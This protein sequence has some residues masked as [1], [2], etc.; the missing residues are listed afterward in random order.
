MARDTD[1]LVRAAQRFGVKDERVLEAVAAVP[2]EHFVPDH[3]RRSAYRDRPIP[4]G[5]GQT[6][7]QPSLIAGMVEAL[8]LEGDETVLEVGTGYGYQTALLAWLARNAYSIERFED[9]A[10]A[11]RRNLGRAG[12]ENATVRVGDGSKGWPE[13][14]PYQGIVVSAAY[15]E[16]PTPLAEQLDEG[17]RL[18]MPVGPGGAEDVAVFV[19]E[20]GDL[21]RRR[22]LTG[23]RFVRLHGEH[24]FPG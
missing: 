4:I 23:A 21:Q 22:S 16:V 8:Q 15:T 12:V 24:G 9:L 6:T 13:H 19:K 2:R 18:V 7:S 5:Q 14:A 17:G 20:E 3:A 11:A 1:A 10:E